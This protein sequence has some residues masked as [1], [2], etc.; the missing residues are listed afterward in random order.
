MMRK[1]HLTLALSI[2]LLATTMVWS[3]TATQPADPSAALEVRSQS[4]GFL[5]P[6]MTSLQRNLIQNPAVGLVVY[7]TSRQTLEF[8]VGGGS[9]VPL[10]A[11]NLSDRDGDTGIQVEK[12][13]DEDQ[14]RFQTA[15]VER[16]IID[17]NGNVGLG[18][19]AP[20]STTLLELNSSTKGFLPP[21]MTTDQRN[22]IADKVDGMVV[23]DTTLKSLFT[24][25]S[26]TTLWE[27]PPRIQFLTDTQFKDL[28]YDDTG[29][30]DI[31][32]INTDNKR[33]YARNENSWK[34]LLD[35][36]LG[37]H[38]LDL[39]GDGL[40]DKPGEY[41]FRSY[42]TLTSSVTGRIWLD[43]NI[44]AK[45]VATSQNDRPTW[46]GSLPLP[47]RSQTDNQGLGHYYNWVDAQKACPD[48]FHLPTR[49][50]W[51]AELNLGTGSECDNPV[52]FNGREGAFSHL[53]L[54]RAGGVGE[55]TDSDGVDTYDT[56]D[57]SSSYGIYW[58][59]T[60]RS[61]DDQ[62]TVKSFGTSNPS[63]LQWKN[64]TIGYSV[65]CIKD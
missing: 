47:V 33:F 61:T 60:T 13:S 12:N 45:R 38:N 21:R 30:G 40:F 4:Q 51:C 14:L 28:A 19:S 31:L 23:Y 63:R 37:G 26:S 52:G 35:D 56:H 2:H 27:S 46:D 59:S 5:P 48:G 7:N 58:S 44:G 24:Y 18:T 36:P 57:S 29:S 20:H 65:R 3:Q 11:A 17:P 22:A 15:G 42:Q 62:A 34:D 6:R 1:K 50:E 64:K 41:A 16:M 43:R 39:D 54:I 49:A 53:K 32:L 55:A 10:A 9:W 25:S 8:H